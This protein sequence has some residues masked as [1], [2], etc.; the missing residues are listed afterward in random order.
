M[1]Q[2]QQT[3]EQITYNPSDVDINNI[4]VPDL[5]AYL[6]QYY[7]N[8]NVMTN[9]QTAIAKEVG[10]ANF[11][12]D[13]I[14][15]QMF[16]DTAT[17]G[18][19]LWENE[20]NVDTDLSKSLSYRREFLKAKLRGVGTIS[21]TM[22]RNTALAYTNADISITEYP[23]TYSFKIKFTS[24]KGR[25][26]NLAGFLATLDNIKPAHLSYTYEFT[27][28]LWNELLAKTWN[29]EKTDGITW[30]ILRVV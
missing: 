1:Y 14:V 26:P 3:Y 24:M 27:F 2:R 5:L 11:E 9:I 19:V 15:N 20:L 25:P 12:V 17:W 28:T 8:S 23:S 7:Q 4:T 13:D 6:P 29:Q 18:L 10:R 30:E 16:I 22:L 21:K